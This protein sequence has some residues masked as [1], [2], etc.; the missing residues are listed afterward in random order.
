MLL[1]SYYIVHYIMYFYLI[2]KYESEKIHTKGR[3]KKHLCNTDVYGTEIDYNKFNYETSDY[4][5]HLQE[6]H[7]TF[8]MTTGNH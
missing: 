8:Q 5:I 6:K 4:M 2:W 3:I 1:Y 7:T